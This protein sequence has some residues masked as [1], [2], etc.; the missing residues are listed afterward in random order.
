MDFI[1]I[2]AD[3]SG[4]GVVVVDGNGQIKSSQVINPNIGDDVYKKSFDIANRLF[5]ICY[6]RP[7]S[8]VGIHKSLISQNNVNAVDLGGLQ[9]SIINRLKFDLGKDI[10]IIPTPT[11][12]QMITN[13]M[14]TT[15]T[16]MINRLDNE[17]VE[18][19]KKLNN[20][21]YRLVMAYYIGLILSGC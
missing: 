14:I 20:K 8:I 2:S 11:V 4:T 5:C 19:F 15:N 16:D 3:Y 21:P 10:N 12:K 17:L 6:T 7:N 18:R 1:G 9:F 13:N